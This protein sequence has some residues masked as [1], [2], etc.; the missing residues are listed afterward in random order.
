MPHFISRRA[1]SGVKHIRDYLDD[2]MNRRDEKV[3]RVCKDGGV[4]FRTRPHFNPFPL[5]SRQKKE[6]PVS[7][8][9]DP[10]LPEWDL[11]DTEM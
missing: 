11:D 10:D 3:A 5:P 4:I 8:A 7:P 6:R 9:K 1:I 2:E